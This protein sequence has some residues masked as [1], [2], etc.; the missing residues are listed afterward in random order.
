MS[1]DNLSWLFEDF[2]RQVPDVR[3]L[4]VFSADGLPTSSSGMPEDEADALAALGA[5]INSM[6]ARASA[7]TGSGGVRG[8]LIES[9]EA[10]LM[11]SQVAERTGLLVVVPASAD[12][13]LAATAVEEL[14]S[15]VGSH[16]ATPA[17]R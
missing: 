16:L 15:Q 12:L 8:T 2:R 4:I 6:V 5:S 13:E 9:D 14:V 7:H 17:R 10:F 3:G 11:L 1:S